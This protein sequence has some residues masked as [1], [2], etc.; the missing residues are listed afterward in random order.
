MQYLFSPL[1]PRFLLLTIAIVASAVLL[2]IAVRNPDLG[3]YLTAPLVVF[4]AFAL[5]PARICSSLNEA[6]WITGIDNVQSLASEV[7]LRLIENF[8]TG[9]LYRRYH[10]TSLHRFSVLIIPSVRWARFAPPRAIVARLRRAA[11]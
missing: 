6:P 10:L 7:G 3:F 5:W 1:K 9:D 2:V 4:G 11:E 8:T